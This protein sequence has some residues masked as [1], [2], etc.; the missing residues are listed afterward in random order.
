M[1]VSIHQV[2]NVLNAYRKQNKP[3]TLTGRIPD[4]AGT[5]TDTVTLSSEIDEGETAEKISYSLLDVLLKN[6]SS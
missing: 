6:R 4:S 2:G 5:P 1:T 3:L